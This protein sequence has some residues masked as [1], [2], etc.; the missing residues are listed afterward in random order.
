[1]DID[2]MCAWLLLVGAFVAWCVCCCSLFCLVCLF[3]MLLLFDV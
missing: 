1:M 2:V 3:E